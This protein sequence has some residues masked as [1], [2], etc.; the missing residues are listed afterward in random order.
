MTDALLMNRWILRFTTEALVVNRRTQRL[1]HDQGL[2]HE[3]LDPTLRQYIGS[4]N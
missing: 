1:I 2:G 4:A 3:L